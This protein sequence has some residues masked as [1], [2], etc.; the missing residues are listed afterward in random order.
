[1]LT[2]MLYGAYGTTGRL[3]VD[4]AL[5]R[6]HRPVLAGRDAAMLEQLRRATGLD[7]AHVSLDR[8]EE[9]R[10]AL[11]GVQC[12]VLAAGPY[13]RTGPLMR[14]A[15]LNARCS[16][17][18]LNAAVDDFCE[19]LACDQAARAAGVAVV[20]GV[21]YGVVFGECLA[22]QTARQV[23]NPTSLRLSL[24]TQ[25]EGRSRAATL[26]IAH[27]LAAGG[28]AVEHGELRRQ[29]VASSTWRC[30]NPEGAST[31]YA[32]MPMAEVVAAHRSTGVPNIVAGIPLSLASAAVVRVAG[33][34]IG[35]LLTRLAARQ[36]GH[37]GAGP[38]MSA[39]AALRS[40]LWAEARNDRGERAAAML[41]TG[42]GYRAAAAAAVRAVESLLRTP[43]SG[44]LTP[45]QA[46]GADFALEIPGTHIQEFKA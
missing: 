23:P 40:R 32:A 29:P 43:R 39:I 26:S 15:C 42:E 33:P 3:I 2:W 44:A 46:F 10:S 17:L 35:K 1:M 41:E 6:G 11:A 14:A 4:E 5:R 8:G 18:D 37:A 25:N 45:V 27:A 7:V 21:G 38:S 31:R 34:W 28:F 9:V 22:A 12:V 30:T 16:Y 19:A 24:A 13:E 36:S 20:P